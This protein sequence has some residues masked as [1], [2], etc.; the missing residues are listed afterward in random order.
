MCGKACQ[1]AF[2]PRAVCTVRPREPAYLRG[3]ES[4]ED[5]RVGG[6]PAPCPVEHR[7]VPV[8]GN[9]DLQ[10]DST[11]RVVEEPLQAGVPPA[12]LG[13][14]PGQFLSWLFSK[15]RCCGW[16]CAP[17]AGRPLGFPG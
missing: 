16:L 9:A 7:Q 2:A 11:R 15:D 13:V 5:P 4:G 8:K 12:T 14:L 17:W 10:A 1:G 3:A 6:R